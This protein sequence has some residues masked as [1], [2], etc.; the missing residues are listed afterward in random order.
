MNLTANWNYPTSISFG[1]GRI[2]EL[3]AACLRFG[4]TRPLLVTDAGLAKMPMIAAA[5]EGLKAAGLDAVLFHDVAPN[6]VA[7]NVAAG[8]AAY[9]AASHDGVIAFG[10]G[11]A[12]DAGKAIAFMSGQIRPLWDFEDIGDNY[13]RA[14]VAGIAP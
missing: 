6:P 7:E 11:S 13:A 1:P 5:M 14:S 8:V 3:A 10:G 4:M 2:R 9:K 12:L